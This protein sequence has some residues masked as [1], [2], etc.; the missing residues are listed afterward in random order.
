[1]ANVRGNVK[2]KRMTFDEMY[3]ET[4]LKTLKRGGTTEA[5]ANLMGVSGRTVERWKKKFGVYYDLDVG[6]Y[7]CD[8]KMRRWRDKRRDKERDYGK[9][10]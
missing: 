4:M 3:L 10:N 2:S 5:A 9:R 8:P 7:R 6:R 1:M